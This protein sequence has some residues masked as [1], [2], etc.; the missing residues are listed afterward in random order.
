MSC[1]NCHFDSR[2]EAKFCGECGI[3]LLHAAL[4]FEGIIPSITGERK[5]VTVMFSDLSGYTRMTEE[6]DPEEVKEIMSRIFEAITRIVKK[7]DGTIGRFLGDAAMILFGFPNSH[8]DD[9]VRAIRTATQIHTAVEAMSPDYQTK[10]GGPLAM[11]TGINSGLVVISGLDSDK[12]AGELTGDTV[13]VASRLC[14]LAKAGSI[15]VGSDTHHPAQPYFTFKQ[16]EL[17]EV[18]GK[19]E[20][21]EA[22]ELLTP[23]ETPEEIRHPHRLQAKLVGRESEMTLFAKAVERLQQGQRSIVS[24]CGDPGTGKTRLVEEFRATLDRKQF[25]W[26]GAHCYGYTQNIPYWPLIDLLNRIWKIDEQDSPE[27]IRRKI[28]LCV[29]GILGATENVCSVIGN[30]YDPNLPGFESVSPE[31]WK[32]QLLEAIR[33][34]LAAS[35][36]ARATVICLEDL[37][38]ADPPS[39]DLLRFILSDATIPAIFLCI[40][41]PPFKLFTSEQLNIAG[42]SRHE[43]HLQDLSPAEAQQMM[44]SLLRIRTIPLE[45]KQFIHEKTEGNPFYLEEV[46]NSL[47]ESETL[48]QDDGSWKLTRGLSESGISP[49][50]HGVIA[51]RVDRLNVKMKRALQEA[52]VIGRNFHY[53]IIERISEPKD[54]L[55]DCLGGL[56]QLDLIRTKSIHP[57]LE[58]TFKHALTQEV[59][60]NGL[61]KKERQAVHER[62][63]QAME[64]VFCDRLPEMYETLAFHYKKG[65]SVRKAVDYL[66]KSGEKSLRRYAL[67]E[68][69]QYFRE[70]YALL[71]ENGAGDEADKDLLVDVLIK[72]A[73]VYYYGGEYRKLQEL[74]EEHQALAETLT[75]QSQLGMYYAWLSCAMW[76]REMGR[77]AYE[78]LSRALKLGEEAGDQLLMG[79]A[80]TWLTW[81]SMELG[82]LDEAARFAGKAQV[83]CQAADVDH[84]LYFNSLAGL[85][86]VHFHRGETRKAFEH[87]Q[88]LLD[89]GRKHSNVRSMVMGCCFMGYSHMI[90]GDIAAAT[91]CFEEAI[92]TSADP[93]YSQFP[94]LALS[95][96]RIA[97]GDYDGQQETL[98]RMISFSEERGAEYV[99]TPA[100]FLLG[101]VLVAHGELS[102]GMK[103]LEEIAEIWLQ[104][105]SKLRY[106]VSQLVMGRIYAAIAQGAGEKKWS[107]LFRNLGFLITKAPFADRKALQ[108]LTNAIEVATEMGARDTLGRASL[109]LGLLHRAKGRYPQARECLAG[110]VHTFEECEADLY[111]QKAKEAL[112][113]LT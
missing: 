72:W 11:H 68:S 13:N 87:G 71:T 84:F 27:F 10:I 15:L 89:F 23:R 96:A 99:G 101:A 3:T 24:I 64:E 86:Y 39:L 38:W 111:L 103:Y 62:I 53:A 90:G 5:Q 106:A 29:Y 9:A 30:L 26:I 73:F 56:E 83:L 80:Y 61:L 25:Q 8:E 46:V 12:A 18:K 50:I 45:L 66:V 60:Y 42:N 110:A 35:A 75:D 16:C 100:K 74:L 37:H 70:A 14:S 51:A 4:A 88:T 49:T 69:H 7:Y 107:I 95:Y 78:Y 43:I 34:I 1:P 54:Y 48:V 108:H 105:G 28:E 40:Y 36:N 97:H 82:R 47:I 112:G 33:N 6:L 65:H 58:Y 17:L 113:S 22:Y 94:S 79:Y 76:H 41:R 104:S 92:R 102:K 55:Q 20:L 52:S 98:E 2:D 63:G 57:D 32:A 77:E 109:T 67:E 44:E 91:S 19:A 21:V 93:W 59:V 85:A 81:T 31:L